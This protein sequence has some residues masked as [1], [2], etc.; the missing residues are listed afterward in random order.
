M[1]RRKAATP[2]IRLRHLVYE[3]SGKVFVAHGGP[4]KVVEGVAE[5][6]LDEP[7]NL[8]S[9]WYSGYRINEDGEEIRTPGDLE[10]F[11]EAQSSKE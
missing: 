3:T 9:L 7:L 2:T 1:G 10:A 8:M 5:C 6:P 4:K 11:I